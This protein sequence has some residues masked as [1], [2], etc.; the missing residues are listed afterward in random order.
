MIEY[1]LASTKDKLTFFWQKTKITNNK[2][3][4]K[5]NDSLKK[6]Y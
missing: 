5:R 2:L 4:T 3:Q 6:K 1:R